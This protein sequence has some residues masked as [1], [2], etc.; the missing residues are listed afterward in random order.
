MHLRQVP[1]SKID[2]GVT[3]SDLTLDLSTEFS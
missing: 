3:L 2:C 1:V